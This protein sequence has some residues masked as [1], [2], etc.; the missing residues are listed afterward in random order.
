MSS[1]R[2]AQPVTSADVRRWFADGRYTD[3]ERAY[4]EY[5]ATRIAFLIDLVGRHIADYRAARTGSVRILDIGPHF[6]IGRASCR[7]RV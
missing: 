3:E 4:L 2:S 7:E 5:H 1:R 6:E